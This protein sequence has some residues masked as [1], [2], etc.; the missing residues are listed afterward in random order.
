MGKQWDVF[1]V[2]ANEER[3]L[4]LSAGDTGD[5]PRW[6]RIPAVPERIIPR[7]WRWKAPLGEYSNVLS[8]APRPGV[9]CSR[10]EGNS[11]GRVGFG[12]LPRWVF[13]KQAGKF[14]SDSR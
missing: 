9:V 2:G 6:Q 5:G 8:A 3:V 7:V 4:T 11:N 12:M 1:G 13:V 14:G 10:G